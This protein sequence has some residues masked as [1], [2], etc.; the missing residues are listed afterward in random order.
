MVKNSAD[1]YFD[2]NAPVKTNTVFNTI[3]DTVLVGSPIILGI[4]GQT[5]EMGL[6]VYPNPTT[7]I[8]MLEMETWA[9]VG[10][11]HTS[12]LQIHITDVMG[13]VVLSAEW[14]RHASPLQIQMT[15][16]PAGMYFLRVI[17]EGKMAAVKVVKE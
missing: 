7:G 8:L 1:I 6:K 10:A 2:F 13:R 15:A 3:N 4:V 12:P 14:A 16:L 11:R 17:Q 5:R 9:F